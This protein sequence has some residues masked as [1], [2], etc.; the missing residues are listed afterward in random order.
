MKSILLEIQCPKC[1]SKVHLKSESYLNP[2]FEP[3][4]KEAILN[5]LFFTHTCSICHHEIHYQHPLVYIDK[6]HQAIIYLL[7]KDQKVEN[8]KSGEAMKQ[9]FCFSI[10]ELQEAIAMVDDGFDDERINCL[11]IKLKQQYEKQHRQLT[12]IYYHDYDQATHTLW[13]KINQDEV[14]GIDET[15][16]KKTLRS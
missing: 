9:F 7:E 13:F 16:Y 11:K 12:S 6:K 3:E 5:G 15:Y 2:E 4:L 8:M 1:G 14:I 10:Q